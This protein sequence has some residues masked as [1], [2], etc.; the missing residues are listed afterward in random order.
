MCVCV[1]VGHWTQ[2]RCPF[3]TDC[4]EDPAGLGPGQSCHCGPALHRGAA[5]RLE[6]QDAGGVEGVSDRCAAAVVQAAVD[7][8]AMEA[9]PNGG[10]RVPTTCE[11]LK[12]HLLLLLYGQPPSQNADCA[13]L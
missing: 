11:T 2:I 9:P 13:A 7:R 10:L 6:G 8:E 1:C 12:L 4:Q 5:D 3:L